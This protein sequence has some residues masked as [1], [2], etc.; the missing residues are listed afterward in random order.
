LSYSSKLNKIFKISW[1]SQA[2]ISNDYNLTYK[3]FY[4]TANA[5]AEHLKK[6][7]KKPGDTVAIRLINGPKYC[8][9][10]LACIIGNFVAVPINQEL[11]EEEQDFIYESS[12]PS[13]LIDENLVF[14]SLK[15]EYCSEPNFSN[16]NLEYDVIF[17]TSGTTGRPK[18]VCHSLNSLIGNAVAFN[19]MLDLDKSLR[20]YHVLPMAYMAGFLNTIVCPI[21]VGGCILIGPRFE[22]SHSMIFWNKAIEWNANSVWLTPTLTAI[23]VKFTR[24]KEVIRKI[25]LLMTNIFCGTAPLPDKLRN[26]FISLFNTPL[27]ESFGMSEILLVSCQNREEAR[28]EFNVGKLLPELRVLEKNSNNEDE[29][30]IKSPWRLKNYLI[31]GKKILPLVNNG[32]MSTG[33]I[34]KIKNNKLFI[35]GRIKDLIIRGGVN[36]F[37]LSIE[38]VISSQDNVEEVI[39]LGLPHDFWGEQICVCLILKRLSI[40]D[41]TLKLIRKLVKERI[42]S[43]MQPDQYFVLDKFPKNS[44]GK[45][46]KKLLAEKVQ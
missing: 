38:S 28:K 26:K 6:L 7:N 11:T 21:M 1:Q 18:G 5:L 39:V 40:K 42:S 44:N 14:P 24:D 37:P 12:S 35:T 43:S 23:I 2:I 29:L 17:F 20:M 32:Y 15:Q 36:V 13:Y 3:E 30:L 8:I 31:D 34:G 16:S 9:A 19:E 41:K 45:I 10:Y 33:D 4:N 27:Q 25:S 46:I 22:P